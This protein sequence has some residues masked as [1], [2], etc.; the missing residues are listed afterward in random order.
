[1]SAPHETGQMGVPIGQMGADS[2]A[3]FITRTYN[4]LMGAI[5]AFVGI[6][7]L[8]FG[9]GLAG[10]IAETLLS[11]PFGWITVLGGFMLVGWL[12]QNVAIKSES[13]SSQYMALGAYVLAEAIIFV[14][15]LYIANSVAPGVISS[16]AIVTLLGFAGLTAVVFTTRKDFSFLG[17]FV[18]F[19]F[20]LAIVA[21]VA[22][23]IVGFHMGT[24]FSVA[25]IGL[26][27]AAIL[28]DTSNVLHHYPE[29]RYVAASLSLF[30]SVA[31]L[32][33]YVL[34]LFLSA[35]D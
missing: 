1:M 25:M 33:W 27:G 3:D 8:L 4:H 18:R 6:E 35:D 32:F 13:M 15:L 21:I 20:I 7:L 34:Q 9:S 16:A 5:V 2:R 14:P 22:A 30:A 29:D 28:Y 24:W 31:V 12:A 10:T 11:L 23:T 26:A 19:G 17:S